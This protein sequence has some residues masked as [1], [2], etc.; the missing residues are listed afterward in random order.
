MFGPSTIDGLGESLS[1]PVLAKLPIDPALA[2]AVDQGRAE[3][4]APN[5]MEQVAERLDQM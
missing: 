4:Y 2:Q 1:L 5:P 3:D